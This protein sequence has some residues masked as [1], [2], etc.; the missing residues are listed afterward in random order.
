[1]N[2]TILA[3]KGGVGKS[4]VSLML[5][6]ALRQAGKTVALHDWD[7]QGTS[8]KALELFNGAKPA[9]HR[10]AGVVIWDTPPNLEH[11][12]TAT[13]VRNADVALVLTSPA[14][15]DVWEAEDAVK[16]VRSR[17]AKAKVHVLFN[18]VRKGTIL[19]RLIEESAKQISAPTLSV[20][21]GYR[22]CYQHAV[23]QGWK[24]LD[25]HAREEVL[26]LAV[27]VLSFDN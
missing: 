15:A 16:F 12:A 20:S 22:E 19:G 7:P 17:N 10:D 24:A 21:L 27:S 2:I 13:A 25:S 3:K 23:G 9:H 5:Y 8:T 11:T 14:L 18:K 26:Q 4:I 1:M 6:E